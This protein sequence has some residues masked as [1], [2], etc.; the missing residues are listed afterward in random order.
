MV[1]VSVSKGGIATSAEGDKSAEYTRRID[2]KRQDQ[3]PSEPASAG[4]GALT[5]EETRPVVRLASARTV[6][7]VK[8][9]EAVP[10]NAAGSIDG[11]DGLTGVEKGN[12][13]GH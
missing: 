6:V 9:E 12:G 5:R 8:E 4:H 10:E 3:T 2:A 11:G 13:R 1:A 7:G